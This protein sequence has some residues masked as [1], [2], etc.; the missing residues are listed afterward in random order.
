VN[1]AKAEDETMICSRC[2]RE[3]ETW[4]SVFKIY[5]I[6][7]SNRQGYDCCVDCARIIALRKGILADEEEDLRRAINFQNRM[8]L[9]K[10][11]RVD[12]GIRKIIEFMKDSNDDERFA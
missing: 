12:P 3:L 5:F 8:T 2:K 7:P 11:S 6:D 10:K 4:E 1:F 9:P